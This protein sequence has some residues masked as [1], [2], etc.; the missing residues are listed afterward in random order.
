VGKESEQILDV[1]NITGIAASSQARAPAPRERPM[2]RRHEFYLDEEVSERLATMAAKPGSS[3]RRS[4][5]DAIKAHF[6][7]RAG[8][9]L[10]ER[11]SA[12]LAKL[13][14]QL[15]RIERDRQIVAET[16][17]TRR[18]PTTPMAKRTVETGPR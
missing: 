13:S 1:R 18:V 17:A 2:K 3:K 4:V 14:V 8:S 16:L 15:G 10:D 6:D 5:T 11:C 12:R 7:R 9:A